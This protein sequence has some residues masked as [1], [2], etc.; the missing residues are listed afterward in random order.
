MLC[1]S[2]SELYSLGAPKLFLSKT[3]VTTTF[4]N[5]PGGRLRE[6]QLYFW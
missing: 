1:L 6:L 4:P 5:L 3:V 2:G